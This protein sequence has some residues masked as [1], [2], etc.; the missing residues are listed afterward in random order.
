M[1]CSAHLMQLPR[2]ACFAK[3]GSFVTVPADVDR[4]CMAMMHPR[5]L[6]LEPLLEGTIEPADPRSLLTVPGTAC[7]AGRD[8]LLL[9]TPSPHTIFSRSRSVHEQAHIPQ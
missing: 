9:P 6:R 5:L 2:A 7:Q 8:L 3:G 4:R 1:L